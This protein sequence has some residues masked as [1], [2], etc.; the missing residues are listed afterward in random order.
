M[1]RLRIRKGVE[2]LLEALRELRRRVPGAA[3]RVAGNGE[4]RAPLERRTK[5]LDLESAVAF[6]G[7]CDAARVR[8]LLRG[9]AALV[10]PSTYEGM[11]LVVLEAMEAG[12]PVVASRVS[13][14]PEV[15]VDGE[16]GWLVPPED[17][18][19]LARA[20][21]RVLTDP[22]EARRRGGAGRARIEERYRPVHAAMAWRAAVERENLGESH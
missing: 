7:A 1:G 10:V 3:L 20:L 12:V 21:E 14:I 9:A 18:E 15:V 16:T 11:P 22:E 19:A 6:L 2:V 5:E 4:H 13:G 8:T 17:P